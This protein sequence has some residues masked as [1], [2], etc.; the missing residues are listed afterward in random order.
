MNN[1]F[2]TMIYSD[3]Y[4]SVVIKGIKRTC[5]N[6]SESDLNDCISD[7]YLTALG[8][9]GLDKHPDIKGWLYKVARNIAM[10]HRKQQGVQKTKQ[11]NEITSS[12]VASAV[13]IEETIEE[14]CVA[15]ISPKILNFW[16]CYRKI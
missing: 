2:I 12:E 11:F 15:K 5:P 16:H 14:K 4:K 10:R 8:T 3:E 13:N 9:A 6:I 1:E 7:V